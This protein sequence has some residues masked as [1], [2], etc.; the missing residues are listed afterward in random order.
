MINN[1]IGAAKCGAG[2]GGLYLMYKAWQSKNF[3]EGMQQAAAVLVMVGCT[4]VA[5]SG[6]SRAVYGGA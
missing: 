4:L 2:L 5:I 1:V 6:A 3:P